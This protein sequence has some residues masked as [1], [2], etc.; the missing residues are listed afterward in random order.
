MRKEYLLLDKVEG[1][2]IELSDVHNVG[3]GEVVEVRNENKEKM[4]GRVIKI[5]GEKVVVQVF[6]STSGISTKN[7][8]VNFKGRPFELALSKEILGRVFNGVG[9][10]IDGGGE[11]YSKKVFNVN[12]RPINPVAREYPRNYIQTGI[13]SIDGLI[14][15]IRGQKLPIFSGNGLP[16]NELAAQIVQQAKI[17]TKEG[18]TSEFA[19]VFAAIGVKHDEADFLKTIFEKISCI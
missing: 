8:S 6:G 2:L 11:I 19:I 15:L 9:E 16:H 7:S 17:T 12:G 18:E 14:T 3:Y 5:D 1:P 13:S 4:L 10:P